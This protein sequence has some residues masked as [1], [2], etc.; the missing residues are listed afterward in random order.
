MI[1][2]WWKPLGGS[3]HWST[4]PVMIVPWLVLCVMSIWPERNCT[5][6]WSVIFFQQ[7]LW[8]FFLSITNNTR[9]SLCHLWKKSICH[10]HQKANPCNNLLFDEKQQFQGRKKVPILFWS[11]I[12]LWFRARMHR[13]EREL[14][15]LVPI[16]SRWEICHSSNHLCNSCGMQGNC[17]F[18]LWSKVSKIASLACASLGWYFV[19]IMLSFLWN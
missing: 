6:C 10:F 1:N 12:C 8:V 11:K 4:C 13:A 15:V 2:V 14:L 16:S 7:C 19:T 18:A 17:Q 3:V 5:A 9:P